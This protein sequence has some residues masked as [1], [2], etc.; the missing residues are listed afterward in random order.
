MREGEGQRA[1]I[2]DTIRMSERHAPVTVAHA[3]RANDP[4][5]R[6]RLTHPQT[7]NSPSSLQSHLD[8]VSQILPVAHVSPADLLVLCVRIVSP[9]TIH[10]HTFSRILSGVDGRFVGFRSGSK[11]SASEIAVP[12]VRRE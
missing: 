12:T 10:S 2:G 4:A 9:P 7:R 8:S 5:Q 6:H 1:R 11:V 3:E